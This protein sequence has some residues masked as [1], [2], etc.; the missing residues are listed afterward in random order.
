MIKKRQRYIPYDKIQK[1]EI[2]YHSQVH[3]TAQVKMDQKLNRCQ[4]VKI[5]ST[6]MGC[7]TSILLNAH[8]HA[9]MKRHTLSP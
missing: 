1:G 2:V 6:K 7:I 3:F 9:H 5:A 4:S 8:T